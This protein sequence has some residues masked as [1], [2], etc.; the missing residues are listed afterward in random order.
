MYDTI[1]VRKEG[2]GFLKKTY[3]IIGEYVT[4]SMGS[5]KVK[6]DPNEE[7]RFMLKRKGFYGSESFAEPFTKEKLQEGQNINIEAISLENR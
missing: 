1:V 5:T 3:F 4:D 7:Y 2:F 6:V